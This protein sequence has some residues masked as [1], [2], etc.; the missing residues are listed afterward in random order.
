MARKSNNNDWLDDL[1]SHNDF[2]ELKP[3][4]SVSDSFFSTVIN[5]KKA[6]GVILVIGLL[7]VTIMTVANL[8][9]SGRLSEAAENGYSPAFKTRYQDVGEQVI[10]SYF[11][12]TPMPIPT[13]QG[14]ENNGGS[15]SKNLSDETDPTKLQ[16]SN[17]VSGNAPELSGVKF[18]YGK[19]ES[20]SLS[21]KDSLTNPE[22]FSSPHSEVL[23]YWLTFNG[24]LMK[25]CINLLTPD[26]DKIDV[27]PVLLSDPSLIP[28]EVDQTPQG[29]NGDPSSLNGYTEA[30]YNEDAV[31][32]VL[33]RFSAAYAK[34]DQSTL[35]QLTQDSSGRKYIGLGGFT[36]SGTPNIVWAASPSGDTET[37][38]ARISF[39][40]QQSATIEDS[41]GEETTKDFS[42]TQVMDVMITKSTSN[43]PAIV[44]W[45]AAGSYKDLSEYS[46][47]K[48]DND[49]KDQTVRETDT[50]STSSETES[51]DSSSSSDD[52]DIGSV[53]LENDSSDSSSSS[54]SSD[55]S[56]SET[57]SSSNSGDVE[58]NQDD[59]ERM[60]LA[61]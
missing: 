59:C 11:T 53:P 25:S 31:K 3:A 42:V 9:T 4:M 26:Q 60:G 5:S 30:K 29:V 50:G 49:G 27:P 20:Y 47:G 48:E 22:D 21:S 33:S 8:R 24:Q 15:Q 55:T 45:G 56:S 38:L 43:L 41:D 39:P 1:S 35:Q 2:H 46:V 52:S 12:G 34:N 19:Q 13:A 28:V 58:M 57:E 61:C 23:C 17:K 37:V 14:V 44:S 32:R 54:D 16:Q 7:L 51:S 6:I 36:T 40:M 10:T 18:L